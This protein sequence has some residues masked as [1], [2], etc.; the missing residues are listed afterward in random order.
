MRLWGNR[1]C[2]G[3]FT[4]Q[5]VG[6]VHF[7]RVGRGHIGSRVGSGACLGDARW[8]QFGHGFVQRQAGL[9]GGLF[10]Q[11]RQSSDLCVNLGQQRQLVERAQ[12]QVVQKLPRGGKQT[13]AA[14][15]FAVTN[16]LD[17]S[18][19]PPAV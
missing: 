6:R 19:G 12:A 3:F 8:G 16:H 11:V 2:L 7:W 14:D 10:E 17:P 18:R 5:G 13:G 15:G 4:V 1:S 9:G